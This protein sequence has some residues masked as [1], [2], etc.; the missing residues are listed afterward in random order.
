LSALC[1]A[2]AC[3]AGGHGTTTTQASGGAAGEAGAP[4]AS[5]GQAGTS[6]VIIPGN[7]GSAGSAPQAAEIIET[8]PM[9]FVA[10]TVPEGGTTPTGG[11]HLGA[12]MDAITDTAPVNDVP[13]GNILHAIVRDFQLSHPDFED[14]CCNV[15]KGIVETTLGADSKPVFA[16]R[17]VTNSMVSTA[18]NFDQ[19]YRTLGPS[20]DGTVPAVNQAFALDLWL[21]P[22]GDGIYSFASDAFFPVDGVGW[23]DENWYG[24]NYH[25][26]TE[27]H[28]RFLYS[29]GENFSF[30]GDDDLWVFMNGQLAIDIGGVHG[31]TTESVAL[32][33]VAATLGMERGGT[34]ALD[35]FHAERHSGGSNFRIDTTLQL[36]DCGVFVP[37]I[38]IK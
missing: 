31:A 12:P 1:F 8:L 29:G 26:T 17:T 28:T 37:D 14:F 23:G 38:V 18:E 34:Y 21:A 3:S 10:G 19:W 27:L 24:H 22:Q 36:V 30:S 13:C 15:D 32:D 25:F 2:G 16:T 7:A 6:A 33:D 20:A 5:G 9:G 4:S 35:L 11:Y